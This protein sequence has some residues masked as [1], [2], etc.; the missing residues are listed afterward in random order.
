MSLWSES[1]KAAAEDDVEVNTKGKISPPTLKQIQS[2]K[3]PLL[4]DRGDNTTTAASKTTIPAFCR[5]ATVSPAARTTTT[6]NASGQSGGDS[7]SAVTPVSSRSRQ[8]GVR[9]R[10]PGA[11]SGFKP[12]IRSSRTSLVESASGASPDL[13]SDSGSV[14]KRPRLSFNAP[15]QSMGNNTDSQEFEDEILDFLENQKM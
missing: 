7:S 14:S 13:R 2:L 5:L 6:T 4:S 15:R 9:R 8:L 11:G 12:P 1:E 3:R 10:P